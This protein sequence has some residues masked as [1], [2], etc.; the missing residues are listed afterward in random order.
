MPDI[1]EVIRVLC[2]GASGLTPDLLADLVLSSLHVDRIDA[3]TVLLAFQRLP[4][5][6]T[7][8]VSTKRSLD[9]RIP[10]HQWFLSPG[11][12]RL[13]RARSMV[14]ILDFSSCPW[15]GLA[16]PHPEEDAASAP[17]FTEMDL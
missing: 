15:Q 5:A 12:R 7:A 10:S 9:A 11:L 14:W 6:C 3:G 4:D 2:V 13:P 8:V 1:L 16:R 17:S